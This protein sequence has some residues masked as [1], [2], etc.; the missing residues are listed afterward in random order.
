SSWQ[1]PY[2]RVPV[3]WK[4]CGQVAERRAPA[5]KAGGQSSGPA[6]LR[7]PATQSGRAAQPGPEYCARAHRSLALLFA[8]WSELLGVRFASAV[9][10]YSARTQRNNKCFYLCCIKLLIVHVKTALLGHVKS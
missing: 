8:G 9:S 4:A 7:R 6:C 3:R 10:S 2:A 5:S 1:S